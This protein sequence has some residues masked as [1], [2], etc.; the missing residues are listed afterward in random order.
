MAAVYIW[1]LTDL[2]IEGLIYNNKSE[3]KTMEQYKSDF[4]VTL[5]ILI[6]GLIFGSIGG[7]FATTVVYIIRMITG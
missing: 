7:L 5:T 4:E 1:P 3:G 2:I 6:S